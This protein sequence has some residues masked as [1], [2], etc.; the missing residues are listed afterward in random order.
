[1]K[2]KGFTIAEVL[3]VVVIIAILSVVVVPNISSYV[4]L[5][6]DEYNKNVK[7]QM[8]LSG[9]NYY[10]ENQERLPR[11]TSEKTMDYIAVQELA[12]LKYINNE[13]IDA[14]DN[15]CM[16]E[17][18]VVAV[19]KGL[20]LNY[21]ACMI[22]TED[23]DKYITE[24]EKFYC[25]A[26]N[27]L[28]ESNGITGQVPICQV[29]QENTGYIDDGINVSLI[30][31]DNDGYIKSIYVINRDSEEEA[32]QLSQDE[33]DSK[34][35][36]I[37]KNDIKFTE[38]GLNDIYIMD[39]SYNKVKCATVNYKKPTT[40]KFSTTMYDI[41]Q[42]E[43][44]NHKNTGFNDNELTYKDL[45]SSND[46]TN[47][48]IYVKLDYY[49]NQFNSIKV[50]EKDITGDKY[51]FITEE[52]EKDTKIETE[53]INEEEASA[54]LKTKIDRTNPNVTLSNSSGG[55]W[56]NEDVIITINATDSY[57]GIKNIQ[58]SFDDSKWTTKTSGFDS[59]SISKK[60]IWTPEYT[61][62]QNRT[63]YVKTMDNAG[64]TSSVKS[65]NIKIDKVAPT[66]NVVNSSSGSWTDKDV[67]ITA[68]ASDTHSGIKE[69]QYN[70]GSGWVSW[71]TSETASKTWT[72]TNRNYT[73]QV[74]AIDNAGNISSVVSTQVK[75][76]TGIPT[77]TLSNSSGG[78]WTN[79]D[80]IITINATDSYSGI[81]NIQY[82]FDDSKWT[83]KTSGFDS[84]SI[85]KKTIWT[86]EYTATQNR[87]LYVKATDNVGHV[88]TVKSTNI[89]I[90][91][92]APTVNITNS[93]GGAW[94]N[95]DVKITANASDSNSGIKSIQYTT[96]TSYSTWSNST[97]ASNTWAKANRNQTL[98][99]RS[100]DKAGNVSSI[101]STNIRQDI[102]PPTVYSHC[103][104]QKSGG[105]W[106]FRYY[107]RD[108]GGSGLSQYRW[109]Y[110]YRICPGCHS[111]YMCSSKS[112]YDRM[113]A[114]GWSTA[115][116]DPAHK[117]TGYNIAPTSGARTIGT[118][119]RMQVR[120][121][122]GNVYTSS[123]LYDTWYY[124]GSYS[125]GRC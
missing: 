51:F 115:Y 88:T 39:N 52:G 10:A 121:K 92:V 59:G 3:A 79:E 107:M 72:K 66:V 114:T 68:N 46:W 25:D 24:E 45:Y 27:D 93:S 100:I 76:D 23:E 43:Y 117:Q 64:N 42:N 55:S 78:S 47:G 120:D 96:G 123:D 83:T 30:A 19:N 5:S 36:S 37:T 112:A 103:F 116:Y 21:Y 26:I 77:I 94:T 2:R 124:S 111:S 73:M 65:T 119:A 87:T 14:D 18:Y 125:P 81:K 102:T 17:S 67:K 31:T 12:T 8:I 33:I 6:K 28:D 118:T 95:K 56:T 101:V 29:D 35:S 105:K 16:D 108:T 34:Q 113:I 11:D 84:G 54:T 109:N 15:S 41:T 38:Y 9:K 70:I 97:S 122:A 50:D 60:T 82:S 44:N 74:R 63:L 91:K 7:K 57:S 89:K 110:C 99:V 80:V 86:P 90:D 106:M 48:Y 75:Q 22:C 62:T 85:S 53:N 71:S 58:Y 40:T 13:F 61:A 32:E 98:K 104:Y 4:V 1:M 49:R 20:G 69:I